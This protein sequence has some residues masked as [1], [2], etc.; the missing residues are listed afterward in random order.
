[1]DQLTEHLA[2]ATRQ[3]SEALGLVRRQEEL[4]AILRAK[5][6]CS[7]RTERLLAFQL[8][9]T[10]IKDHK[11]HLESHIIIQASSQRSPPTQLGVV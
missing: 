7:T 1:M 9:A 11:H 10:A 4:V 2:L 5:G 3:L 8:G 6:Q